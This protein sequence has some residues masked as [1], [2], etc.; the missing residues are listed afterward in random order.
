MATVDKNTLKSW[1]VRGARPTGE[2]FAAWIDSFFHKED[3]VP[4]TKVEG[5]QNAFDAKADRQALETVSGLVQEIRNDL[6]SETGTLNTLASQ[7]YAA[8]VAASAAAQSATEAMQAAT[9]ATAAAREEIIIME[10]LRQQ[11]VISA[12]L[13]PTIMELSYPASVSIR[14]SGSPRIVA[15]LLPVYAL[16]NVLFLAAG[17]DALTVL[18]D[19]RIV[20]NHTGNATVHVI[21]ANATHLYKTVQ[22]TVRNPYLRKVSG[23]GLRITSSGRLRII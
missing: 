12:A 8:K 9:T 11:L 1:F 14:N 3:N 2:Q 21:P 16:Q 15:R 18:P 17:G 6:N 10:A 4:A 13:V 22:V 19:G 20:P 7:T 23:G 5:L